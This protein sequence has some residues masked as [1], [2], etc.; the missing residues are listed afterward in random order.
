MTRNRSLGCLLL[1]I[2]LLV[3]A[4]ALGSEARARNYPYD[5]WA[6][7]SK[8]PDSWY[9][10]EPGRKTAANILSWQDAN[11][12]WPLMAT[13]NEP[14]T[15]DT[16]AVGP[17]GRRGALI[18]ATVNE[19]RFLARGYRATQDERY[20]EATLAGLDFILKAQYPVGG[21]PHSYPELRNPYDRYATFNDDE[22]SDLMRLL[23]EVAHSSDFESLP[24]DKRQAARAAFD[25]GVDF[26]LKSQIVVEGKLT[27]WG[28]QHDEVT[29]E[30]RAARKFEP[31]ALSGGESGGVL[32][33]LMSIEAPSPA[34]V[35]AIDAGAAWYEAV[36]IEGLRIKRTSN[37]RVVVDDPNAPPLWARFYEIGTNRPIFA[38]RDG[39]IK[40]RLD[41]IEQERRGGYNWYDY[42]GKEVLAQYAV[43]RRDRE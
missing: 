26:I 3:S 24:T 43:W 35:R 23:R 1:S 32:S 12:G 38:G 21:W 13:I 30:P 29:L 25:K 28:Q 17:W 42:W 40:Y 2:A 37:D 16:S 5:W 20:L 34:V 9:A 36:K 19:I 6:E 4:T 33:L 18:K 31:A 7:L 10:T 11:G 22:M 14:W 39:V 41:E 8:Q 15:G 27:V